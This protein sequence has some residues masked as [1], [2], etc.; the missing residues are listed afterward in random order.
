MQSP[1]GGTGLLVYPNPVPA[2]RGALHLVFEETNLLAVP[3]SPLRWTVCNALG[4]TLAEGS[5]DRGK[6]SLSTLTLDV[7][8]LATGTH[9]LLLDGVPEEDAAS[10][11]TAWAR[12]VV[13]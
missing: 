13:E 6:E 3:N 12:F 5:V 11:P 7:G 10:R 8:P 2:A 9:L 4:Q 1:P